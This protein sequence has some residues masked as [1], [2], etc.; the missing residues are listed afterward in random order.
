MMFTGWGVGSSAGAGSSTGDGHGPAQVRLRRGRAD[1]DAVCGRIVAA[2]LAATGLIERLPFA[3][4]VFEDAS[5]F[6][7]EAGERLVA[8]LAG[9]AVAFVDFASAT[10]SIPYIF[11]EPSAQRQGVGGRLLQAAE[12]ALAGPAQLTVLADNERA[13][14]WFGRRG[15]RET[16]RQVQEDWHGGRVVWVLLVKLGRTASG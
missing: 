1:D 13:L 2:A 5:P 10:G 16:G 4:E 12:A 7:C 14:V 9:R 11:V 3:R 6:P 8:E 15:Y